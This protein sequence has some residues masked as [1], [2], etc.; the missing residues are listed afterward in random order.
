MLASTSVPRGSWASPRPSSSHR[1]APARARGRTRTPA[2]WLARDERRRGAASWRSRRRGEWRAE[3]PKGAVEWLH[4][5]FARTRHV[6]AV[7]VSI[8]EV[9]GPM[10]DANSARQLVQAG[11]AKDV[12]EMVSLLADDAAARRAR[13]RELFAESDVNPDSHE[14]S[15]AVETYASKTKGVLLLDLVGEVLAGQTARAALRR[16]DPDGD[17]PARAW[18]R[19]LKEF[20]AAAERR[21]SQGMSWAKAIVDVDAGFE[22]TTRGSEWGD[23]DDY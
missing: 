23:E 19:S 3:E 14:A 11:G 8:S 13:A 22:L 10:L 20:V 2:S 12:A 6:V 7:L 21:V 1:K 17:S 18:A 4:G 15:R 5:R 16:C 9:L